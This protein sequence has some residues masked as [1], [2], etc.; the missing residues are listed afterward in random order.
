MALPFPHNLPQ[1]NHLQILRAFGPVVDPA[2]D[3]VAAVGAVLVPEEVE[4]FEFKFNAD[5]LPS[6]LLHLAHGFAVGELHLHPLH[7]YSK[8]AG[9]HAENVNHC[10]FIGRLIVQAGYGQPRSIQWTIMQDLA[11]ALTGSIYTHKT[12]L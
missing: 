4:A 8:F 7:L 3:H 12:V 10:G 9:K 5:A 6:A 11:S 1:L 2:H